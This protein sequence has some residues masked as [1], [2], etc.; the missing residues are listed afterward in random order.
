MIPTMAPARDSR[1]HRPGP[2]RI[3]TTL[4]GWLA[5]DPD[6]DILRFFFLIVVRTRRSPMLILSDESKCKNSN[7]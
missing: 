7:N 5:Y 4:A 2:S 3:H 6:N 1:I